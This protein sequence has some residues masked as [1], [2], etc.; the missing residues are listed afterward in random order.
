MIRPLPA[1]VSLPD[2]AEVATDNQNVLHLGFSF[3]RSSSFYSRFDYHRCLF[4]TFICK[5]NFIFSPEWK[6]PADVLSFVSIF[7]VVNVSIIVIIIMMMVI[8]S[9]GWHSSVTFVFKW[10]ILGMGKR[11]K[12]NV[13]KGGERGGRVESDVTA[14]SF[15]PP[16]SPLRDQ[17]NRKRRAMRDAGW[18]EVETG[19]KSGWMGGWIN[20]ASPVI[21]YS[22]SHH[23]S[24]RRMSVKLAV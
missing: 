11:W 9:Y 7:F 2:G 5:F 1:E 3:S 15:L 16:P 13:M 6:F 8:V 18:K 23:L 20:R 19:D 14:S 17:T 21:N 4:P 22:L 12:R 24:P 10:R